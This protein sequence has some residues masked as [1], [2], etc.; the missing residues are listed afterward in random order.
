MQLDGVHGSVVAV[1]GGEETVL[2]VPV[3]FGGFDSEW[4]NVSVIGIHGF[5]VPELDL[6]VHAASHEISLVKVQGKNSSFVSFSDGFD[7]CTGR[8]LP[9]HDI[10]VNASSDDYIVVRGGITLQR[11]DTSCVSDKWRVQGTLGS[12]IPDPDGMFGRDR[13]QVVALEIYTIDCVGMAIFWVAWMWQL[14]LLVVIKAPTRAGIGRHDDVEVD[15]PMY[16]SQVA[17]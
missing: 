3:A 11:C 6:L 16:K 9:D 14:E 4:R 10:A 8:E 15:D 7:R 17:R 5:P 2:L 13:H 1:K 12:E